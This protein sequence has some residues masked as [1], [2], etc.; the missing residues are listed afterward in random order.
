MQNPPAPPPSNGLGFPRSRFPV[1]VQSDLKLRIGASGFIEAS[2][3]SSPSPGG[4]WAAVL[5]W[6]G[7]VRWACGVPQGGPGTTGL[8]EGPRR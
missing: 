2:E 3:A 4:A 7:A 5:L 6:S 1:A 8:W